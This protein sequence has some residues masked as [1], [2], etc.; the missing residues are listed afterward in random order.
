MRFSDDISVISK[1]TIGWVK[2]SSVV[3]HGRVLLYSLR[4]LSFLLKFIDVLAN[5]LQQSLRFSLVFFFFF[6]L[7]LLV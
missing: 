3:L 4:V 2:K 1:V 6:W 7:L 5:I